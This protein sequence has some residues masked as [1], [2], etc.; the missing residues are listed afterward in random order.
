MLFVRDGKFVVYANAMSL[1]AS[2]PSIPNQI[3]LTA[4]AL[5]SVA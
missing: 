4:L 2:A 5:K 1:D 3:D